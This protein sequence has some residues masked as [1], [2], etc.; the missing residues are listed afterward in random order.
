[1]P[2][3]TSVMRVELQRVET[4]QFSA[5]QWHFSTVLQ[6][7]CYSGIVLQC[8]LLQSAPMWCAASAMMSG[9]GVNRNRRLLKSMGSFQDNARRTGDGFPQRPSSECSTRTNRRRWR[10]EAHLVFPNS[11]QHYHHHHYHYHRHHHHHHHHIAS[12]SSWQC[13]SQRWWEAHLVFPKQPSRCRLHGAGS[14]HHYYVP[15][16]QAGN[17]FGNHHNHHDYHHNRHYRRHQDCQCII[18]FS[19]PLILSLLILP[20]LWISENENSRMMLYQ[21]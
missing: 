8:I 12:S 13:T 17:F 2:W 11:H 7:R 18:V 3:S 9:D 21:V 19:V 10:W 1:M 14:S 6:L 16:S 5:S 20:Q 15:L 4:V